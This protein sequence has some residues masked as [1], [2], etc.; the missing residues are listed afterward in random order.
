MYTVYSWLDLTTAAL[1][2][3]WVGF[4]NFVPSLLGAIVVFLV[5]LFVANNIALLVEKIIDLL[6][7]DRI[8]EKTS[9]KAFCQKAEIRLDAG[10]F[11]G[12]IVRWLLILAFLIPTAN[13]LKLTSVADFL[14][15]QIIGI[16]PAV[17][18]AVL[19]ILLAILLSDFAYRSIVASA[20]GSGIQAAKLLGSVARWAI[21]IFAIITVLPLL[22]V[23]T[24]VINIVLIGVV[25]MISLAGGLAF[26]LGGREIATDMLKKFKNEVQ[27][28]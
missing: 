16:L 2:G 12:Q 11:V 14:S 28:N 21:I 9:L 25:A 23:P 10:Y 26:G 3:L 15:N 7:I 19:I 13:I 18:G 17:I 22:H 5:G 1:K 8:L 20:K 6:K 27:D 4:L 24:N